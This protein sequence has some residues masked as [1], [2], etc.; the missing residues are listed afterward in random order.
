MSNNQAQTFL[1]FLRLLYSGANEVE[2]NPANL[3]NRLI[4][5]V[6]VW[7]VLC[8]LSIVSRKKCIKLFGLAFAPKGLKL[9]LKAKQLK[10]HE[11]F[12]IN[13]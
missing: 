1:H 13:S 11:V 7:S 4:N 10:L 9:P 2:K 6:M 12:R 5:I 8:Y 3:K